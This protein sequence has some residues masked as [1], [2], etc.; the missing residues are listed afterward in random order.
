MTAPF[1]SGASE[2][3]ST[4]HNGDSSTGP[5]RP[6][7]W[8]DPWTD[9]WSQWVRSREGLQSGRTWFRPHR[10]A[11]AMNQ[12]VRV[13]RI[14]DCREVCFPKKVCRGALCVEQQAS[15]VWSRRRHSLEDDYVS[16][17]QCTGNHQHA[18]RRWGASCV[19]STNL[20]SMTTVRA[21]RGRGHSELKGTSRT[22]PQVA[23]HIRA[24]HL[25]T[26]RWQG[27]M[28]SESER[29]VKSG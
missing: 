4:K 10:A 29:Q 14:A 15:T 26:L 27:Q 7:Q 6:L 21:L 20:A 13:E 2:L 5:W 25:M 8:E 23:C 28:S 18:D 22:H 11:A 1:A 24:K 9:P 19:P 16:C 12:R 17:G 3:S